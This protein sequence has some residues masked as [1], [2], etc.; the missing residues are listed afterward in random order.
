MNNSLLFEVEREGGRGAWVLF[1]LLLLFLFFNYFVTF[2][3][4]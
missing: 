3:N 1:I 2:K 4:F